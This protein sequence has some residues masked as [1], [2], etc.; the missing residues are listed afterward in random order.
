[1]FVG[2][3]FG[4]FVIPVLFIIFQHLQEKVGRDKSHDDDDDDVVEVKPAN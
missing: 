2:T 1:M 3:V 4:V